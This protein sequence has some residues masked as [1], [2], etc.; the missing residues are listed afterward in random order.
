MSKIDEVKAR[1]EVQ[2]AS[3]NPANAPTTVAERRRIP[4]NAQVQKFA[5]DPIPGYH[6][7][8]FLSNPARLARAVQAGYER[9]LD[10][11]VTLNG[12]NLAGEGNMDL[13]SG[14][15]IPSGAL[16]RDGQAEMHILMKIKEEWYQESEKLLEARNEGVAAALRG[17]G[18]VEPGMDPSHRY[19]DKSRTKLPDMFTPKRR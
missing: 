2:A 1:L 9:V 8:W 3:N 18:A 7:H 15:S 4:M 14:V 6:L 12:I 19:I 16:G 13:G 10:D 17:D 5:V 11:E